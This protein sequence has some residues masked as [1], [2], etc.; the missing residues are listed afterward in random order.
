MA[1]IQFDSDFRFEMDDNF[2]MCSQAMSCPSTGTSFSSASSAYDPFTPTSRRS[3]PNELTLDFEASF[4]ASQSDMTPPSTAVPKYMFGGAV[5]TEPEHMGFAEI[6]PSTPIKRMDSISSEYDVM[7][8]MSLQSQNSIGSI[9]PSNTYPMYTISPQTTMGPG[10][11]MMTPTH[12]ISGS[13]MTDSNSSWS[14]ANDSPISFFPQK[15]LPSNDFES[16][17]IERQ[18]QSPIGRYYLQGPPPS[19]GRLRAHRKMIVHEIQRKTSELQ[20]AQIRA[21]RK[22]SE[23][24][25]GSVDVVKRAMCKCD[26]PGCNKAFR[27]NEHL[28]RHKQ[29]YHGEGPNRFSCEFCGKDQFN[30][31]DNLNNHRKLHARPN[32]RNRGVEFI[33]AAVPIIEAEERSRKRRAP[34]KSKSGK[35]DDDDY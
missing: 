27:R 26:Y 32:S 23:K 29:T 18:C 33:P 25:D 13:E 20:R 5:K 31:Q 24:S 16:L 35:R 4:A 22:Q 11:F 1:T 6:L 8:N 2:S 28:K 30:R 19:P 17:E 7:L 3:T 14:C 12:S 34:P 21:S 10:S 15:S 9:T